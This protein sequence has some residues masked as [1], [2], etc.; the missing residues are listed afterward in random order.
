MANIHTNKF[1]LIISAASGNGSNNYIIGD[2]SPGVVGTI[3]VQ[4]HTTAPGTIAVTPKARIMGITGDVPAFGPIA[5]L[6]LISGGA[7]VAGGTYSTAAL[8]GGVIGDLI[9]IPASG[10]DIS[11]EV[12][13]T[14]GVHVINVRK[15]LGAAA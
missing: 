5:Y 2:P 8:A 11:L 7:A 9:H 12:A 13:L 3:V 10:M 14:D 1:P 6:S 4:I 15:I